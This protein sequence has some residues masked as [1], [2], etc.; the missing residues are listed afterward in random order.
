VTNWSLTGPC[1][2]DTGVGSLTKQSGS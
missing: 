1:G 2:A